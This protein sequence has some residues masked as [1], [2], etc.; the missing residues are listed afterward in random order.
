[1]SIVTFSAGIGPQRAAA[2]EVVGRS[3]GR[4]LSSLWWSPTGTASHTCLD[5]R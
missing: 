5:A 3:S 1:M 2:V 4:V